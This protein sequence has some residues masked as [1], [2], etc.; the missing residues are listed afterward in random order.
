MSGRQEFVEHNGGDGGVDGL[1]RPPPGTSQQQASAGP[2]GVVGSA[3][4]NLQPLAL[5]GGM[6]VWQ[7]LVPSVTGIQRL[8]Q[9]AWAE[10]FDPAGAAYFG[11]GRLLGKT[12]PIGATE[13]SVILRYL[14][15]GAVLIDMI[16]P[17]PDTGVHLSSMELCRWWFLSRHTCRFP[18]YLQYGTC[19]DEPGGS[20]LVVG[21]YR[22]APFQNKPSAPDRSGDTRHSR[23]CSGAA[24]GGLERD[25][26]AEGGGGEGGGGEGET[27]AQLRQ[28][29]CC[30][31]G[32]GRE[33]CAEDLGLD[34][35]EGVGSHGCGGRHV[36]HMEIWVRNLPLPP[37]PHPY[38]LSCMPLCEP[39]ALSPLA[40]FRP[41][42]C[43]YLSLISC[44]VCI[45]VFNL[46]SLSLSLP[47]HMHSL[48]P[49]FTPLPL[50][51]MYMYS[52]MVRTTNGTLC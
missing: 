8:L 1:T 17:C 11:G 22:S 31:S 19:D 24:G 18:L 29:V 45:F 35:C 50:F 36:C 52:K 34:G 21:V 33:T 30:L 32:R 47:L 51:L 23:H 38:P 43:V 2:A 7:H 14:G 3:S 46:L 6:E 13:C 15:L 49:P 48:P 12:K 16:S 20:L 27:C 44:I 26:T 9:Q 40:V 4:P 41:S 10:S 25:S 28:C 5:R 37:T 39:H 42:S